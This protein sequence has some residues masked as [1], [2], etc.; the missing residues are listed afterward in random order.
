MLYSIVDQLDIMDT[1]I[2]VRKLLEYTENE[3]IALVTYDEK[4]CVKK[5]YTWKNYICEISQFSRYLNQYCQKNVAI[6]S[7]NRP[8]WFFAAL[9]AVVSRKH[10]CGIY[11]TNYNDHCIHVL[12]T[13]ECDLLVIENQELLL[14]NYST[15]FNDLKG[16]KIILIDQMMNEQ[17]DSS[18]KDL[19]IVYWSDILF[20]IRGSIDP[21]DHI[22]KQINNALEDEIITMIFTSGTTSKPKAVKIS[23]KNIF[24]AVDGVLETFGLENGSEKIL[25]YLPLSH[26][27]GLALDLIC[28]LWCAG[29]VHFARS[30]ALKGSLKNS[31]IAVKPT[32]FLGVPRVWE[33]FQEGMITV[34]QTRYIGFKGQALKKIVD[35]AK[36][37]TYN[38]TSNTH[39]I[40]RQML[41]PPFFVAN[42]IISKAKKALGLDQCKYFITGSAPIARNILQYFMSLNMPIFEIYGMSETTGI[43]TIAD[44]I[45]ALM[46]SCGKT[47]HKITVKIGNDNEILIKG[48]NVFSGYHNYME[49]PPSIDENGYFHT[50]DCGQLV[51][52]NLYITG[53]IKE[54]II[55]SGGE[56]IPPVL[57]ENTIHKIGQLHSHCLLVG[58]KR[59]FLSLL[60]FN[61]P[62]EPQLNDFDV[63]KIIDEYNNHHAISNSQKIQKFKLIPDELT[64][65]N[66]LLTPTMKYKRFLIEKKYCEI[67]ESFY[68]DK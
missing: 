44:P 47:P 32:I 41:Y 61:P 59:K 6:H 54:L 52:G 50:G 31:L 9:G 62:E 36:Q 68:V 20:N 39:E 18:L 16:I 51:K 55:T 43:I 15:V 22:S 58:D 37:T 30:D 66:N 46:G 28:P 38:Y 60:I 67:I 2:I 7:Y 11:N 42:K 25:S 33:K 34:A 63:Q 48:D 4:F 40:T 24:A 57:I 21:I 64:V 26:I 12:K 14:N 8:E 13:G 1:R 29:Q 56:N 10:F 53:R 3:N 35:L 19:D 65:E 17:L 45:T 5:Q 27:A 23:H 49:D